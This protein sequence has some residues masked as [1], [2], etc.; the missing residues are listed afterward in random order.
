M[1]QACKQMLSFFD[2]GYANAVGQ[3]RATLLR[4]NNN[5]LQNIAFCTALIMTCLG[6][7]DGLLSAE[8]ES[9]AASA[10]S[11]GRAETPKKLAT[12]F[13]E[14]AV[15]WFYTCFSCFRFVFVHVLSRVELCNN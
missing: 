10:G 11:I 9:S 1:D 3:D 15:E 12:D 5:V 2:L 4:N 7:I 8:G 14:P 13:K 6:N